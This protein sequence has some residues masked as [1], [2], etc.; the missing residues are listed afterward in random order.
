M[1]FIEILCAEQRPFESIR[2]EKN[3][4]QCIIGNALSQICIVMY[5]FL[6]QLLLKRLYQE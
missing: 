1:L 6:N 5:Y 3:W 4:T 2:I